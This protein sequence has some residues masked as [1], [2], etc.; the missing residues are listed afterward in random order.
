MGAPRCPWWVRLPFAP[1]SDSVNKLTNSFLES[2]RDGLSARLPRSGRHSCGGNP[3][4]I[5][6]A[7][8]EA[9]WAPPGLPSVLRSEHLPPPDNV[10]AIEK[11]F[12]GMGLVG[13]FAAIL[14]HRQ[15]L[16]ESDEWLDLSQSCATMS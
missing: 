2:R 3:T 8:F 13:F 7:S 10:A 15:Q 9:W 12:A 4:I 14:P 1:A 6:P 11:C 16:H 5:S